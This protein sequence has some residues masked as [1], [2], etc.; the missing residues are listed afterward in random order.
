MW[1]CEKICVKFNEFKYQIDDSS[2]E[3]AQAALNRRLGT[4]LADLKRQHEGYEKAA[5]LEWTQPEYA[6]QKK[7]FR[8]GRQEAALQINIV[9]AEMGEF[10]LVETI[11]KMPFDE[12]IRV[13]LDLLSSRGAGIDAPAGD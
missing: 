6:Q 1:L 13:L 4:F 5:A 9:L 8:Q 10:D 12:R 2:G 7:Q 11:Q 3:E